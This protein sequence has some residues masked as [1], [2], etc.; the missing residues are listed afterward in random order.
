MALSRLDMVGGF[1]AQ[2]RPDVKLSRSLFVARHGRG[3]A[4]RWDAGGG[5]K[6]PYRAPAGED[7]GANTNDRASWAG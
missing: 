3:I 1:Q 6:L 4:K 2:P 7:S 5:R